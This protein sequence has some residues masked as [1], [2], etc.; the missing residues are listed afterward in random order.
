MSP[1]DPGTLRA[2]LTLAARAPSVHNTQPWRWRWDDTG[3]ELEAD[4]TRR[5]GSADADGRDMLL[6]CGAAL[7]HLT[8]ALAGLG[9]RCTVTRLPYAGRP[10]V[11]AAVH[12]TGGTRSPDPAAVDT[13]AAIPAR[14]TDRRRFTDWPL[15]DAQLDLLC[16]RA[17]GCG[18]VLRPVDDPGA[19]R[20][21]ADAFREAATTHDATPGYDLE[22]GLW[23]G[24]RVTDDGVPAANV[25]V[26][27]GPGAGLPHRRFAG[28]ELPPAPHGEDGATLLVLGTSS[29]DRLARLRA[30]EA[31]SAVLL[32]ATELGLATCPLTEP[33]EVARTTEA[34][35]ERVLGGSLSPQVVLRVG[36][37]SVAAPPPAT[38]R[39]ALVD[40]VDRRGTPRP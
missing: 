27:S 18:A 17:S 29:D 14:R 26:P 9:L 8:V 16:R 24:R 25:P 11:V 13:A 3:I 32:Q 4:A 6:S 7:H 40:Q 20:A 31:L 15:T 33:L 34:V 19:R 10:E 36:W 35:A 5:L 23:S 37:P 38:P 1:I 28:A 2:A 30:G 12:V 39:R 21:L 22:L